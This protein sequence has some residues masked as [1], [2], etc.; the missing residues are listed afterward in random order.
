MNV[1]FNTISAADYTLMF[2]NIP[3]QYKDLNLKQIF[4][5]LVT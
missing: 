3:I 1:D 4:Q 5:N 2:S